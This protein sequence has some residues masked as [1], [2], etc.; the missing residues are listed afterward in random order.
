MD[1]RESGLT[2][3]DDFHAAF[4]Q[5]AREREAARRA[6]RERRRRQ[7]PARHGDETSLTGRALIAIVA[8]MALATA[9]GLIGLWP[10]GQKSH[11]ETKGSRRPN[12]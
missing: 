3:R 1:R 12:L 5:R 9:I 7:R 2:E 4:D 10:H 8:A 6:R 11:S